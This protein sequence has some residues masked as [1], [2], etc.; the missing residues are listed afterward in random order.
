MGSSKVG[1][2]G[3]LTGIGTGRDRTSGAGT[4]AREEV[5][6]AGRNRN[7]APHGKKFTSGSTLGKCQVN[8]AKQTRKKIRIWVHFG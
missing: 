1:N 5:D 6:R 8:Y 3:D 2:G 7:R 4:W